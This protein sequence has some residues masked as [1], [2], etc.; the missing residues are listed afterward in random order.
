MDASGSHVGGKMFGHLALFVT[1]GGARW[2]GEPTLFM[3]L[4][5]VGYLWSFQVH[6]SSG[7]TESRPPPF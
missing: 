5:M 2:K 4:G 6:A 1:G 7:K 3:E